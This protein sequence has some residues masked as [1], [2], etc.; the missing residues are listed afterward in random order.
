M[1][2]PRASS[3]GSFAKLGDAAVDASEA[4][5]PHAVVAGATR[6]PAPS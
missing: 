2:S 3:A 1:G 6:I 4:Q 5:P